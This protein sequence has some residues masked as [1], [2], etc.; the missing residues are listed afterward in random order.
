MTDIDKT[1]G[2]DSNKLVEVVVRMM[3]RGIR[4][5]SFLDPHQRIWDLKVEEE[6]GHVCCEEIGIQ[7]VIH[8][9][10]NQST[11]GAGDDE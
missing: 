9:A 7:L 4:K 10:E 3:T 5:R 2:F 11:E 1:I 8:Q 6:V